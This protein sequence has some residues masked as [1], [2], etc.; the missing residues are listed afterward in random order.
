MLQNCGEGGED[1]I[2]I[3]IVTLFNAPSHGN[4]FPSYLLE[5]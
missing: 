1:G 4:G 3:V 5:M 2:E